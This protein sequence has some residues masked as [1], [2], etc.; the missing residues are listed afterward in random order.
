MSN[1]KRLQAYK[2][3]LLAQKMANDYKVAELD[4]ARRSAAERYNTTGHGVS[5]QVRYG[6]LNE[7]AVRKRKS[8]ELQLEIGKIS[9]LL[10]RENQTDLERLFV[11][12]AKQRLEPALFNEIMQSASHRRDALAD[13]EA[14]A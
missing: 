13:L 12:A 9:A 5:G 11:D 4:I 6:W 10:K 14:Q 2:E 8:Q 3:E 1:T 7:I